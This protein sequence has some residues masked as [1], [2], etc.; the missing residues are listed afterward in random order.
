MNK[1][2]LTALM[3]TAMAAPA[4]TVA[5]A[6]TLKSESQ[7]EAQAETGTFAKI[8]NTISGWFSHEANAGEISATG[9]AS[10]ATSGK[11]DAGT[12]SADV[13][14]DVDVEADV[15][16][17]TETSAEAESKTE[18]RTSAHSESRT[19]AKTKAESSADAKAKSDVD[20][21]VK[22]EADV[23]AD[24]NTSGLSAGLGSQGSAGV[25]IQ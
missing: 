8:G 5:Q 17:E 24:V 3:V 11:A 9:A 1:K 22:A 16:A 25:A 19:D 7:V 12:S 10:T 13:K 23:D 21:D 4:I 14:A 20:A 15:D 2:L 18:S 6:E